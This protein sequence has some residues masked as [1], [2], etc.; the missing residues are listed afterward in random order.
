MDR[1]TIDDHDNGSEAVID[2]E[3]LDVKEPPMYKVVFHNDDYTSMDFVVSVLQQIFH[4]TM[5]KA[6]QVM[7]NVHEKGHGI[8]GV[9]PREMA[10]MKLSE[11]MGMATER[12]FPL[13]VTM[14]KDE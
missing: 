13:N 7:L 5:E 1:K 3:R 12:E 9:Y 14:E 10:E 6:N 11:S 4:H 2:R 8:A